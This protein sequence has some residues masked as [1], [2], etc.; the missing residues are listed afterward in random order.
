MMLHDGQ[1]L[2]RSLNNQAKVSINIFINSQWFNHNFSY[3]V[4]QSWKSLTNYLQ[5]RIS[6]I[7]S[8]PV[9]VLIPV[10]NKVWLS[11]LQFVLAPI[12]LYCL[13][14][15]F[16]ISIFIFYTLRIWV[17]VQLVKRVLQV[18]KLLLVKLFKVVT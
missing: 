16:W 17:T 10:W 5:F 8:C 1:K 13:K 2:F 7:I 4:Y 18:L 9:S 3:Q 12:W 6:G 15:I 14:I 11:C